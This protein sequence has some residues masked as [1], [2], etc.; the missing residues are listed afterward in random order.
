[1][2]S[3]DNVGVTN[4]LVERC[5]GSGCTTFAQVGTAT[6][7][8]YND[9]GLP[10]STSYVYRVRAT[11]AAGNLSDYSNTAGT[12][13]LAASTIAFRQVNYSAPQ[14]PQSSVTVPFT[15]A[16]TGGNLS[17]VVVGW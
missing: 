8:T 10:A 3:S 11:D 7:I 4:Y 14:S 6:T 17:V 5:Q 15:Q 16:Q 1:T 12:A 13:T 9:T 2:A